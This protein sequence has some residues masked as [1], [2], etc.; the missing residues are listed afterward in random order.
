[1]RGETQR[2]ASWHAPEVHPVARAGSTTLQEV[3][4][5]GTHAAACQLQPVQPLQAGTPAVTQSQ[6]CHCCVLPPP[7]VHLILPHNTSAGA[8]LPH[9]APARHL[10]YMHALPPLYVVI[11]P[12][13]H[14]SL[15]PLPRHLGPHIQVPT[16]RGQA[17]GWRAGQRRA[18][19]GCGPGLGRAGR[20]AAA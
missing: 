5:S 2:L 4:T 3:Q 13:C 15:T 9:T 12:H 8:P 14:H 16:G 17:A 1:M 18:A 10:Q 20:H 7:S 6:Q 11:H 19:G